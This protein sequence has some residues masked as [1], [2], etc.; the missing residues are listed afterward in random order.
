M[1]NKTTIQVKMQASETY[2]LANDS[3]TYKSRQNLD[4]TFKIR[5]IQEK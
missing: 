3:K 4:Y 1:M 2:P 5:C